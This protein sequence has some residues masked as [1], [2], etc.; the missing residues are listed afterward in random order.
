MSGRKRFA[1]LTLPHCIPFLKEVRARIWGQ[2]LMQRPWRGVAYGLLL[3]ACSAYFLIEPRDGTTHNGLGPPHQS[4]IKKMFY[5]CAY[6]LI[7][8]VVVVKCFI[9]SLWVLHQA[10][11]VPYIA[12]H[13]SPLQTPRR[14][15]THTHTPPPPLPIPTTQ[16]K[17][18]NKH[19][20][21][22]SIPSWKL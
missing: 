5:K 1:W 11:P 9:D 10:I 13:P 3:T 4:W 21:I 19:Q 14:K 15:H 12:S 22:E 16:N 20:H 17:Q 2:K 6:N 18:T 8:F 7:S